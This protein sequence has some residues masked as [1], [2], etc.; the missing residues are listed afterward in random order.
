LLEDARQTSEEWNLSMV[1]DNELE[2]LLDVC[3]AHHRDTALAC[4]DTPPG[5]ARQTRLAEVITR[6]AEACSAPALLALQQALDSAP[7]AQQGLLSRLRAWGLTIYLQGVMLPY[8]REM[9]ARQ[10][11]LTCRIDE[12]LIPLTTA[13]AAMAAESRRERRAAVE[14]AVGAQLLTLNDL[15]EAQFEALR[16]AAMQLG[17]PSLA[18][19]WNTITGL[20]LTQ[21]QETVTALL[22]ETQTTYVDLLNWAATRQLHVPLAQLRRHDILAL[23]T[24]P[25]YQKYYQP[26]F[27]IPTLQTCLQ[28][29]DIDPWADGRLLWR[30]RAATLGPPLAAPVHI[31]DEIVLSSA[32]VEG[33]QHAALFA[34]ACGHALLWAYT[35]AELP[36][37]SQLLGD[38]AL[39]E[40]NAHMLAEMV[41][42]PSWL[43]AYAR[44]GVDPHYRPWQR[45]ERLYRLRRQLGRFLYTYHL[46]SSDSLRDAAETYRDIM[47]DAC[48]VDY[49]PAY[50]L[51]DWDW[52]YTSLAFWR[53]WSL[54]YALLDTLQEQLATDWFR[55]PESGQ[56]LRQYWHEALGQK[57]D[58]LLSGCLGGAWEPTMLA[59]ALC[60]E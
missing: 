24:F 35:A 59:A 8:R 29:M 27:L 31:P 18:D 48:R 40:S 41:A 34:R 1:A 22:E 11:S 46:Y 43:G 25:N 37:L 14:T 20:D 9:L 4:I 6:S 54:A 28:H 51:M 5:A 42:H 47:M 60:D 3:V 57:V 16:N 33:F 49:L 32:P 58:D 15:F 7:A 30:Q 38:A 19:L 50:Y 52:Q 39:L 12:E 21:Q 45:L 53:G 56:W 44:V 2:P 55:N 23:F 13:F 10:R 17:Y 36:Q 26:G